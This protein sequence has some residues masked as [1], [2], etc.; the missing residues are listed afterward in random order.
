[1]S[2]QDVL[3]GLPFD[4]E[5]AD[6]VIRSSDNIEFRVFRL[7]LRKVSPV[8]GGMF[9]V[10]PPYDMESV[11][12]TVEVSENGDT[13]A[14]LL[15]LC[16]PVLD[17]PVTSLDEAR[18]LL[19]ACQE[20]EMEIPAIRLVGITARTFLAS[21]PF[22]V[23]TLACR[24]HAKEEARVAAFHCLSLP[25]DDIIYQHNPDA[26]D[27]SMAAYRNLLQYYLSCRKAIAALLP[28]RAIPWMREEIWHT[29]CWSRACDSPSNYVGV[30]L[31]DGKTWYASTWFYELVES[32]ALH[33]KDK[34]APMSPQL[35]DFIDCSKDK[36]CEICKNRYPPNLYRFLSLLDEELKRRVKAVSTLSRRFCGSVGLSALLGRI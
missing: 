31:A 29:Y 27:A 28:Q 2:V 9:R 14:Q 21:D 17:P 23:Y 8:F 26:H 12:P 33:L 10:L 15:Q 13:T 5:D 35:F 7:F 19:A 32:I 11:L 22:H 16:Y 20:Y 36:M 24:A 30:T 25:L 34:A 4:D 1:M 3:F 6:V 18:T